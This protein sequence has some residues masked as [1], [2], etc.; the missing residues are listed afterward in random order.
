MAEFFDPKSGTRKAFEKVLD[1]TMLSNYIETKILVNNKQNEIGKVTKTSDLNRAITK[2][3]LVVTVNEEVFES[4]DAEGQKIV[5]ESVLGGVHYDSEKD[6]LVV[7]KGDIPA[8][9]SGVIVKY[10]VDKYYNVQNLIKELYSQ[11]K[12]A[13]AQES[14]QA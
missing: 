12:D 1:D 7:S 8:S 6:K 2:L 4:L 5:A 14:S 9:H 11:Q 10:G 3:D 13:K